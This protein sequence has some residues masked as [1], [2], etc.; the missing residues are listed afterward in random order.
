M[1]RVTVEGAVAARP[2]T[3]FRAV[4]DVEHLPE[5]DDQIV[6]IEFLTDQRSGRGTRFRETRSMNGREM[7]TELEIT[8]WVEGERARMVADTHGTVWDTLFTVRPDGAGCVLVIDMDARPHKL[9]PRIMNPL[10]K[11]FFRKGIEGHVE[12][13]RA[14]CERVEKAGE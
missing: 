7:V 12:K 4:T 6:G 8:E 13:V 9:L 1:T 11:R 10:M 14:H 3:V 2:E 5:L